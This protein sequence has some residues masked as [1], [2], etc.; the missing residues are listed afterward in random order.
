MVSLA[1]G[2]DERIIMATFPACVTPSVSMTSTTS[3]RPRVEKLSFH[4]TPGHS[5]LILAEVASAG[6]LNPAGSRKASGENRVRMI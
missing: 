5:G 6:F 3:K 1:E 2:P 4:R